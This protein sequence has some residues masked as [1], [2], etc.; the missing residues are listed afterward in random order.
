MTIAAKALL[1]RPAS[2]M[3]VSRSITGYSTQ[4][5]LYVKAHP[6]RQ[7]KMVQL[8]KSPTPM[9]ETWLDLEASGLVLTQP[10]LLWTSHQKSSRCELSPGLSSN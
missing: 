10:Q 4:I 3:R 1:E 7:Q 8:L 5:H 9:L 2:H 6:G